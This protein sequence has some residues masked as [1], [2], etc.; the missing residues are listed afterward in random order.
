MEQWHKTAKNNLF[1]WA[2]G[3]N[4]TSHDD[5]EE[6]AIE[7]KYVA[8][9][10][11]YEVAKTPPSVKLIDC[12]LRLELNTLVDSRD[13]EIR[14]AAHSNE[15]TKR[16]YNEYTEYCQLVST[17]A[18]LQQE[19]EVKH[20]VGLTRIADLNFGDRAK[21]LQFLVQREARKPLKGISILYAQRDILTGC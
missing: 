1:N 7:I 6:K 5:I 20:I 16:R 9:L 11:E 13:A 10:L 19:K 17:V 14:V 8:K 18:G 2:E 15:R 4:N 12:L 21:L 3:F